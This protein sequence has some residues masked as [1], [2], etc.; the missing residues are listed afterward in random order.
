[1][2]FTVHSSFKI[3]LSNSLLSFEL[4]RFA[5]AGC[6]AGAPP[7]GQRKLRH[8][9][10]SQDNCRAHTNKKEQISCVSQMFLSKKSQTKNQKPKKKKKSNQKRSRRKSHRIGNNNGSRCASA[11][12]VDLNLTAIGQRFLWKFFSASR[13]FLNKVKNKNYRIKRSEERRSGGGGGQR[14]SGAAVTA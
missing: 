10:Q 14:S 5:S 1:M 13:R 4:T 6:F 8:N 3:P 2:K 11:R 12:H 7:G 9:V